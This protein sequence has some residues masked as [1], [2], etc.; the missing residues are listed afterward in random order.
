[1]RGLLPKAHLVNLWRQI[2]ATKVHAYVANNSRKND[3]AEEKPRFG[4]I[5]VLARDPTYLA[6][7]N[8][9]IIS[10]SLETN[11]GIAEALA[12]VL[13]HLLRLLI[14][15]PIYA[16]RLREELEAYGISNAETCSFEELQ[17]LPLLVS[18]TCKSV[19]TFFR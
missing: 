6:N 3:T 4:A 13:L 11:G 2:Q 16:Q 9:D 12:Y 19:Y 14:E 7:N 1:M 17:Q 18:A 15:C 8:K 5:H 10:E